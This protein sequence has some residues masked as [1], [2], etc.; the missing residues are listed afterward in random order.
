MLGFDADELEPLYE[1]MIRMVDRLPNQDEYRR[2]RH[3]LL[4]QQSSGPTDDGG[5]ITDDQL[6]RVIPSCPHLETVDLTGVPETSDRTVVLLASHATHL[7]G[8]NLSGCTQVSEVGVLELTNK[9]LPLRWIHLNGVVGLTDPSISAI[10]K[11]CS[12]LIELELC[13]LP[14]LSPVSVRDIWSFSRKLRTLRLAR[15]SLLSDK[16]FPSIIRPPSPTPSDGDDKP[17]PQI[18]GTWIEQ[19]PPLVLHHTADNLRILDLTNCK[20]TDDAVEGIVCHA[21]KI[22][23]LVLS[24]CS[25][26]TDHSVESICKLGG[27]LDVLMLAR[28]ANVTDRAMIMLARSCPHLRCV[29]LAFCRNLTDMSVFEL[30]GLKSLRRLSLVR[31]HKLTDIAMYALAEHAKGLERLHVS[32]CDR[33]SLE[34]IHLLLG[35]VESL[36]HLTATGIPAFRRK[37]VHRFSERPP[38]NYDPEQKAA[39]CV[40]NGPNLAGLRGFLDKEA[41]RERDA[42]TKNIPFVSRSDDK[43]DLY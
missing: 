24:G 4:L 27:N 19:M 31:V 11:S 39:Y 15:C 8:I 5:A 40:F 29:D 22:Q 33:L 34:A 3:L 18:P 28:V 37:G 30:A 13:D 26:L 20:I 41:Q 23:T 35:N 1:D 32:Y 25:Q 36:Q 7:Q 17:L 38:S 43:L 12:R 42:E 21:N 9:S 10:A 6:S 14:L 16:A 2:V